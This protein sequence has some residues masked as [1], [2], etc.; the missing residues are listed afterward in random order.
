M[1]LPIR[2]LLSLSVLHPLFALSLCWIGM[3][4]ATS[5]FYF[6]PIIPHF[7]KFSCLCHL[8]PLH[9]SVSLFYLYPIIPPSC[10]LADL[11]P[12]LFW[13]SALGETNSLWLSAATHILSCPSAL[14]VSMRKRQREG[15]GGG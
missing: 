8:S 12:V 6:P 11:N 4:F 9:I 7:S 3:T 5:L 13:S 15:G 1:S 14:T 10:W 2:P